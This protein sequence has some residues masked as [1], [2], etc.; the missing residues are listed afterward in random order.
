MKIALTGHRPQRLFGNNLKNGKWQKISEWIKTTLVQN[1]CTVAY[2][3][4]AS[5]SDMLFALSVKEIKESGINMDL[6][7]VFPCN[8]YGSKSKD[9]RYLSWRR[10]IIDASDERIFMHENWCSTCDDDRDRY[11]VDNCDKLIAIFDG[12]N[13][14]GVYKTIQYAK[15][16]G[17]EVIF[18]P[19]E[20]VRK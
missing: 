9:K 18:C 8:G 17:K 1:G 3:G 13:A 6:R 14:G 16:I 12:I 7:L 5:G 10:E 15:S 2:S 19:A 20:L 11:M 4:M